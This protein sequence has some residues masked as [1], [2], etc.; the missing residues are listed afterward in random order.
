VENDNL[1]NLK[2]FRVLLFTVLTL[3]I[4][5]NSLMAGVCLCGEDCPHD[6]QGKSNTGAIFFIFHHLC[7]GNNCISCN[8]ER[9]QRVDASNASISS[10][11][12]I[13]DIS[14]SPLHSAGPYIF[15]VNVM[16]TVSSSIHARAKFQWPRIYLSNLEFLL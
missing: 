2:I 16:G 5:L 10:S 4:F 7:T 15:D 9:L 12:L 8:L 6:L 11:N 3:G 13:L 1:N 14:F